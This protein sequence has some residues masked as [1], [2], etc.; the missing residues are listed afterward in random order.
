MSISRP[1]SGERGVPC[2][3]GGRLS[4]RSD[5]EPGALARPEQPPGAPRRI[6]LQVERKLDCD[7]SSVSHGASNVNRPADGLDAVG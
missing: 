6:S 7:L 4:F 5:S 2:G 3:L 1:V